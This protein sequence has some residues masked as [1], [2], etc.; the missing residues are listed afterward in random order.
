M[1]IADAPLPSHLPVPYVTTLRHLL[2]HELDISA[3]P[4]LTF[5]EWLAQF[6]E[7]DMQEKLRWF[8]TGEGQVRPPLAVL[9]SH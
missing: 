3:V 5:F 2:T 1:T 6:S 8:C 9:F 7:G 4:R